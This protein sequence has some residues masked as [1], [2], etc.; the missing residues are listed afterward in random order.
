M[1]RT[2]L[3]SLDVSAQGLGC[4]GMSEQYGPTDW[5][6]SMTTLAR[7]IELGVSLLDT[8]DIYGSGHNEVLVGRAIQDH[9]EEVQIATKFGI[10]RSGGDDAVRLRGEPGY[11]RR[12]CDASLLRLGIERIDI[13]YLHRPP[14]N[15]GIEETIGTMAELVAAGKV[16]AIGLSEVDEATL[17]RAHAIHPIAAVESEY[18]LWTRE[19]ESLAPAL[20][21]LGIGLVAYAPL[22]RGYLTGTVTAQ[23]L[24]PGDYRATSPRF[25]EEANRAIAAT[26]REVAAEVGATPAQVALAWV[27]GGAERL[28]VPVV[29]IPGTRRRE[30]LE[31]NAAAADLRLDAAALARLEPLAGRVVGARYASGSIGSDD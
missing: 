19:V 26:V 25:Q 14:E 12:A 16:G 7:A 20:A 9:R 31:E 13:F 10:D 18:S 1:R 3:G 11:V 30:R 27:H 2:R 15:C 23:T 4:L 24:A 6:Q 8:A 21:E 22:G 5:D 29:P 28:G 17:R